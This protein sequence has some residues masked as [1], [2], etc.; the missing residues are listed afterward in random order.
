MKKEN[1]LNNFT[2]GLLVENPILSSLLGLC[3]ALAITTSL[4]NAIGMGISFTL[5]LILSNIVISLLRKIIPYEI[6][7]PI[8]II[9]IATFVTII[10]LLLQAFFHPLY[11]GLGIFISLIVVNCIVLGRAESFAS[12]NN[13]FDSLID[14]LGMGIGYSIVLCII[15]SIRELLSSGVITVWNNFKFDFNRLFSDDKTFN[16]FENFFLSP[17][18]AFIVLAFVI[19]LFTGYSNKRRG[20]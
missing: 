5:I 12:K 19:A 13:V 9:I 10:E 6:R 8:Y 7:I 3:P 1:V 14:G 20:V 18:G 11:E 4:Q 2:K 15:A 17:A 16:L